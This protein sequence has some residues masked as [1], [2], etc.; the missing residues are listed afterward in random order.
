MLQELQGVRHGLAGSLRMQIEAFYYNPQ[1]SLWEPFLERVGMELLA[2][3]DEDHR[4][5]LCR[6]LGSV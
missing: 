3:Q 2:A 4:S 1:Y 6:A 5:I